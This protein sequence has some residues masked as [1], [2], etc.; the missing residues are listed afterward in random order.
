MSIQR[1][2]AY[3]KGNDVRYAGLKVAHRHQSTGKAGDWSSVSILF[4]RVE[5]VG[6]K[7]KPA[8]TVQG[9][10]APF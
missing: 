4:G 3:V 6:S 1:S 8:T 2:S 9:W 7:R 5:K 10:N